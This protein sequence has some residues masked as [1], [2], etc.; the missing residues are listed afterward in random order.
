MQIYVHKNE[1]QLGPFTEAEI[2]AQLAAGTISPQDL[3][4]WDGQTNWAPLGQTVLGTYPISTPPPAPNPSTAMLAAGTA[5]ASN[6][7]TTERTSGLALGSLLS[8]IAS[9]F[10]GITFIVA[11]ILGHLSLSQIRKNPG[12]KGRNMAITGL[13]L[14]YAWPVFAVVSIAILIALGNEVRSTFKTINAQIAEAQR[15]NNVPPAT[16]NAAPANGQ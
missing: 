4:W 14:G 13:V 3:V 10:V 5:G 9:F 12:M 7:L 15:T 1:Q 2:K 8:G 11:I 16:T 6:L